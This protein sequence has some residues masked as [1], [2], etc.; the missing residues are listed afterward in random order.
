MNYPLATDTY[1]FS[2]LCQLNQY[3]VK[4]SLLQSEVSNPP[5]NSSPDW[6]ADKE[7]DIR[8]CQLFIATLKGVLK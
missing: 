2:L 3:E 7:Q 5:Q 4:L 8:T 6:L 1:A